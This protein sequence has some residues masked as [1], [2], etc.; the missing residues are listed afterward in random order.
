MLKV[1]EDQ[2]VLKVL[3]V[4]LVQVLRELLVLNEPLV[5][6]DLQVTQVLKVLQDQME[7]TVLK[8]LLDL[9]DLLVPK[10]LLVPK[11]IKETLVMM[12]VFQCLQV[13]QVVLTLETYGLIQIL[14][15]LLLITMTVIVISGLKYRL[16]Q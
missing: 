4:L 14:V 13:H 1:L 2:L 16:V 7:Q 11:D 5:H 15:S 8:E 12:Q 9:Q 6:K 10:V 3:K